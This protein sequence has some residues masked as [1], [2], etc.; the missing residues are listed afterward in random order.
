MDWQPCATL[1]SLKQAARLRGSIRQWMDEQGVLEVSTPC[2]SRAAVTDTH[3]ES[4]QVRDPLSAAD[5]RF[6]HT[7]PEFAMK[8]LL[9]AHAIETAQL[10]GCIEQPDLYQICPVFRAG[11]SGRYHN[12]QFTLLEWYRVGMDH[13][14][15]RFD[16]ENLLKHVFSAFRLKWPGVEKRSYGVLIKN[17]LGIWPENASVN[18]IQAYFERHDRSYPAAIG[19]DLDAALD[20]FMDEFVLPEFSSSAFTVLTDYPVSQAALARIGR[21]DHGRHVA[22]RFELF[23]GRLELANGFH[24]LSD[25]R[26]QLSRFNADLANRKDRRL[27]EVPL[28]THLIEALDAGLPDCAGIAIGLERLHMVLGSHP[29]IR[30]VLC[31]DDARA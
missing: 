17:K 31:F 23:L 1:D 29:H 24:E 26:E 11:E 8:R 20:L 13:E 21:D 3:I 4:L 15:L 30:D 2:I 5:R 19:A 10:S 7:S 12:T 22:Q 25:A 18:T 6:L 28:D 16:L 27:N 14:A 9:A